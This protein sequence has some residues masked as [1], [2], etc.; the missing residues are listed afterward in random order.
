MSEGEIIEQLV[1]YQS[2]LL[3]GVSV[4]ITIV[5]AYMVSLYTF[6]AQAP[7]LARFFAFAFLTITFAFLVIFFIGSAQFQTGLV[8]AL[9]EKQ[10]ASA[11]A[12]TAAGRM[13]IRNA[14]S[15]IDDYIRYG[16]F[17]AGAAFYVAL[18]LLTLW[19]G[20]RPKPAGQ[21]S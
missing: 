7:F 18:S 10:Q 8:Q 11:T 20:W 9:V 14:Q 15:G 1:E 5:S 2:I 17:T 6:L 4:F 19:T 13:A 3:L 16:I 12:L 21:A